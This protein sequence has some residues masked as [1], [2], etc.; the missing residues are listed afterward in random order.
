MSTE[1]PRSIL[2]SSAIDRRLLKAK[3]KYASAEELSEAVLGQLS[4][5]QALERV[6]HLLESKSPADEIQERRL[7]VIGAAEW[8]DWLKDHRDDPR[9]W[10]QINRA[11]KVLSD[12]IERAN[13]NIADV[14]TKLATEHAQYFVSGFMLG[15]NKVLEAIQERDMIEIDEDEVLAL[16]QVG[17]EASKQYVDSVTLR[18]VDE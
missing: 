1:G 11:T 15:F 12:A 13:I 6:N 9:S 4:P 3:A 8:L 16:A 17:I 2:P 5:A 10:A 18:T 14:S 7:L